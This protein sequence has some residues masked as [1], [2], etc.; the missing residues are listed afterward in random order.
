[1]LLMIDNYDSFTYNLVQY[2]MQLGERVEVIR[3]DKLTLADIERLAPRQ[4]VISPGPCTPKEAGISVAA[5]EHFAGK[6]PI[7]GICLGHQAITEAFG[8]KVVRAD[9]LMHGKTSPILHDGSG[10]FKDLPNPFTA[11]RYHSLL[12]EKLSFPDCLR[13]TAWT[14]EGEIMGLEHKE[15]PVW[16]VQFHPESILTVEGMQLLKNFLELR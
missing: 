14:E 3:N 1:M 15:L 9:R 2:F 7:L 8:G 10:I 11:T 5:I 6:L 16:G 12:A 4:L 13:M